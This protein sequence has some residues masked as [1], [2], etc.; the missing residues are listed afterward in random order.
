MLCKMLI[1]NFFNDYICYD[2]IKL[3]KCHELAANEFKNQI[4][5]KITLY[6]NSSKV[7]D[8]LNFLAKYH[9]LMK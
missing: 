9:P 1:R 8:G 2:C 5:D 4:K 6:A 3:G 7:I